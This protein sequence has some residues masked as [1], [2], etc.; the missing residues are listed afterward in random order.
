VR[1]NGKELVVAHDITFRANEGKILNGDSLGATVI[2]AR[3]EIPEIVT[4]LARDP[5]A[6]WPVEQAPLADIHSRNFK[7]I[8]TVGDIHGN[9]PGLLKMLRYARENSL[10]V[11]SLGDI[12]DYHPE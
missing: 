2:D 11:L 9:V 1:V 5:F 10:F 3:K 12:V 6:T 4:P 7:G 8:L